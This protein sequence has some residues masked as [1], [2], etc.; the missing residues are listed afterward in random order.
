MKKIISVLICLCLI[1]SLC[2]CSFVKDITDSA[3]KGKTAKRFD[4]DGVSI[5]LTNEFLRMDFISEDYEFVVGNEDITLMGMKTDFKDT[6]LADYSAKEFAGY[7]KE[8]MADSNP[9][10]VKE[11]DGIPSIEYTTREGDDNMTCI[12]KFYKGSSSFWILCFT[13]EADDYSEHYPEICKYA[14]TVKCS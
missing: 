11:D 9:T 1:F 13:V 14:K 8:L 10:E 4:F 12:L 3:V 2:G 5:Q 6:A 7:F